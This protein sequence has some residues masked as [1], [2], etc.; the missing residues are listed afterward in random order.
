MDGRAAKRHDHDR[1]P[2]EDTL[3]PF[4]EVSWGRQQQD[5]KVTRRR[6]TGAGEKA[7]GLQIN[8]E[9]ER[10]YFRLLIAVRLR[11]QPHEP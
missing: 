2:T 6:Q 5:D 7:R 8:N 9:G 1:R 10:G 3:G 11:G 4:N